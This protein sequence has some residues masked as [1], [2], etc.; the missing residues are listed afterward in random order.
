MLELDCS[1]LIL[2]HAW[3]NNQKTGS[4]GGRTFTVEDRLLP[5]VKHANRR[6]GS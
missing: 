6:N 4:S 5:S 3:I 2:N 1:D